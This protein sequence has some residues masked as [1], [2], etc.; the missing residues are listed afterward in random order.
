MR[1]YFDTAVLLKIYVHEENS[2]DAIALIRSVPPPLPFSHLHRLEMTHA[3]YLK[4]GRKE[5][6]PTQAR[7][8]VSLLHSDLKSGFMV[9]ADYDLSGS[10]HYAEELAERYAAKTLARSLD[11]LHVA[12]ALSIGCTEFVSF[13]RRQRSLAKGVGLKVLPRKAV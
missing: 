2:D 10:F 13:D 1:R 8:A 12:I 4:A 11:I 7:A 6:T 3:I 5:I 9:P